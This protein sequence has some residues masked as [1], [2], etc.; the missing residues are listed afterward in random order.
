MD[1]RFVADRPQQLWVADIPPQAGGAPTY[2]RILAGFCYVAFITDVF[3]RRIVGW[4]VAPTLHTQQLPLLALE[5]A[6]LA[7]GARRNG[8]GLIHHSDRGVVNTSLSPTQTLFS[9][10]V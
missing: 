8:S 1:R 5:H 4:A 9:P 10:Q 6:L 3:S 7:T 2:V